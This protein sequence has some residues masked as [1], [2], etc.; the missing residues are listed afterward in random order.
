MNPQCSYNGSTVAPNFSQQIQPGAGWEAQN[1][2]GI[3][4]ASDSS[5]GNKAF[6]DHFCNMWDQPGYTASG[7]SCDGLGA[8]NAM[9]NNYTGGKWTGFFFG[10]GM[11]HQWPAA[12]LGGVA[13]TVNRTLSVGYSLALEPNAV[14]VIVTLTSPAGAVTSTTCTSSPCAVTA[15]A[16][17]G[18]HI[19]ADEVSRPETRRCSRRANRQRFWCSD[20]PQAEDAPRFI[21]N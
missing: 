14:T 8:Y 2:A 12:R 7:L 20:A 5:S 11:S 6:W 1:A 18:A 13:P 19:L 10:I 15:D 9:N 3:S 17:Q 16:R 4:F 21:L